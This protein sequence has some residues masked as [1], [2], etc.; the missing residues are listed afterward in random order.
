MV[1][2]LLNGKPIAAEQLDTVYVI[3]AKEAELDFAE[4]SGGHYVGHSHLTPTNRRREK[5][6]G[7]L[8]TYTLYISI[9]I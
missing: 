5:V 9:N 7:S 3:V 6:A 4:R 2:H 1:Q 8:N